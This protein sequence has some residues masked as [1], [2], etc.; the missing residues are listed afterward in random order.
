MN[1]P[2]ARILL[3]DDEPGALKVTRKILREDGYEVDV[4][5]TAIAGL[6]RL[7]AQPYD[8]VLVD[9][10]MPQMDGLE[11]ITIA[12]K[13]GYRT[14]IIMVTA[15]GSVKMAV[16]T[17]RRGAYNYLTK[18]LNFDEV[19]LLVRQAAERSRTE[20]ELTRLQKEVGEKFSP[21]VMIGKSSRLD[22]VRSLI[23]AVAESDA[24][25]LILGET[26]TGKGLVARAIHYQ[27]QRRTQ[28][29]IQVNCGALPET[30]LESELFGHEKGAFTGA[31]R[32]REGRFEL[33]RGGSLF[34]DEIGNLPLT[35][36]AKLLRVLQEGEFEKLGGE[37]TLK[38]DVRIMTATNVDL[39]LAVQK[40]EFRE[41][42]FYRLNVIP[43][44]LPALRERREDIPLLA[45]HFL[46]SFS[47]SSGKEFEAISPEA[48]GCLKEHDWPGNVR[49]LENV[50]ERAVILGRGSTLERIDLPSAPVRAPVSSEAGAPAWEYDLPLKELSQKVLQKLE[51]DYISEM[52]GRYHGNVSL[53]AEKCGITRRS[54]YEKMKDL[55]LRKEDFKKIQ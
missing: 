26:G 53:V 35:V 16:E 6:E 49:E 25:V 36:Q 38:V 12:R 21:G 42:L 50:I 10:K 45:Y 24:T 30:L 27:S 52:L 8:C 14:P 15:F 19:R 51:L 48:M 1:N 2:P 47:D 31:V 41:D 37:R 39:T 46:R 33:A 32:S 20:K 28:P 55:G 29:F 44:H 23:E 17:M 7:D 5:S 43:I 54:L 13:R 22:E 11:F 40:K 9:Y 34:L 18:P 4:A 3:I